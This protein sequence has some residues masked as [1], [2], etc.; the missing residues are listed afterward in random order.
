[1]LA[2]V[3]QASGNEEGLTELLASEIEAARVRRDVAAVVAL[4]LRL[5][6]RHL[7]AKAMGEA[8]DVYRKAL[9]LAPDDVK[10]LR[11][12]AT[13]L[14][15]QE[16]AR[17]RAVVLERLLA[18]ESGEEAGRIAIELGLLWE[19]MGDEERLQRALETGVARAGGSPEVF[20]RLAEF[21][22]SRHAW[23]RLASALVEESD[24]RGAPAE[25]AALLRQA[26][27]ICRSNLG[28]ARDAAELLR[29]ARRF[30][31]EDAALLTDLVQS[32][33]A[34]GEGGLAAEE[35]SQALGELPE[36]S[37]QRAVL[38]QT[39]ANLYEKAGQFEK[40]VQ[41]QEAALGAGGEVLRPALR[42][43]ME[44]WRAHTAQRGDAAAERRAMRHLTDF[45]IRGGEG[46]D[47]RAVLADWCYRHPEDSESLRSLVARDLAEGRWDAVVESAF[48]LIEAETGERQIS[49]AELLVEASERL[50]QPAPA[51]AGLE[52]ALRQQGD[53]AWL[54]E[55]LIALY[56]KVGDRRKQAALLSWAAERS[57]DPEV[58]FRC[59]RQAAEILLREKDLER[60]S[61]ALQ[62]AVAIKPTDR[63]LSWLLAD[64]CM[65]GGRLAEA[66]EIL[67]THMKKAARDLSSTELSSLQHRMA[68]LAAARGDQTGRFEWL[69]RAFETNR[70]DGVVAAEL[71]DLAEET[72]DID[73]A[74]KALRAVTLAPAG[75]AR[76]TPAMAYLR[77]ARIAQRT[78]DRPKAVIFA[79]RAL[80]EDPRL[81]DAAEMLREMGERRV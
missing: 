78:G 53:N 59:L 35:L 29:R 4:S 64:V 40:A 15:P 33:E 2:D 12:L 70:K 10:V 69:R 38:L 65:A 21:Y 28:R 47:A 26:A 13:L 41:D 79:K 71:A 52:S 54:F 68:Q 80:Q 39:R 72:N 46:A 30:V 48:R 50:D 43:A 32:L 57:T 56:E 74:V 7:A 18:N 23:D 36:T 3:Y 37:P 22:R 14:A 31:P 81:L 76:L 49:A 42:A 11:A 60:A 1:M 25:R 24:R 8:R 66:E 45:L 20:D 34:V 44:R 62:Q 5:G 73:L 58:R 75:N 61:A 63:E 67:Q 77:Q 9:L 27:E 6:S 55:K 16:D 19:A 17:E 51:I